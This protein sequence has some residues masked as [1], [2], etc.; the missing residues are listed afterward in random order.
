LGS[1]RKQR[2]LNRHLNLCSTA[3]ETLF[4]G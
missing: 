1:G 2:S 3:V 4:S